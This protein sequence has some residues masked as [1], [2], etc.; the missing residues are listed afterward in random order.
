MKP[1]FEDFERHHDLSSGTS[2]QQ[3]FEL[4]SA[5]LDG[6]VTLTERRQVQQWL[7]TDPQFQQLYVRLRHLQQVVPRL[8]VPPSGISSEELSQRVLHSAGRQRV[9]RLVW[10]GLAAA[11]VAGIFSGLWLRNDSLFPQRAKAPQPVPRME[12]EP[13][14]IALNQPVFDLSPEKKANPN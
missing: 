2:Q 5:Y 6:E 4:L 7:D 12:S 9:L 3:R 11:M 1:N 10:G 14:M 13:L 8:P